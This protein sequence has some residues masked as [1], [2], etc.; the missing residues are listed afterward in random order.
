[1]T[2]TRIRFAAGFA[3]L[4]VSISQ[5]AFAASVPTATGRSF[6][7][8]DPGWKVFIPVTIVWLIV[9]AVWMRTPF[10]LWG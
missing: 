6:T 4:V 7:L 5:L 8:S 9:V 3:A 1:V 10:W 2:Y